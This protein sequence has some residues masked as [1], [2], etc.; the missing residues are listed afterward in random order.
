MNRR[1]RRRAEA[2]RVKPVVTMKGR[3][4]ISDPPPCATY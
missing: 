3:V 4:L 1:D 2:Q